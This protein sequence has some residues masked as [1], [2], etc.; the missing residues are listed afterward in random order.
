[1]P[2]TLVHVAVAGLVGCALLAEDFSPRAVGVVLAAGAVP[3]LDTFAGLVLPGAH[4]SL[5]HTLLLPLLLGGLL[6]ADTRRGDESVLRRHW[7]PSAPR[8][9]WV[10]LA[11]L[12]VGGIAPDLATNGVNAFYPLYDA[13]YAVNGE[14]LLSNQRGVVQTFVEL[15]PDQPAQTTETLHYSTGVDPTPGRE[16]ADVERVFPL[17]TSGI[18][19]LLVVAGFGTVALR[20]WLDR[21]VRPR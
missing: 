8:V 18:Q 4:R 11:G 13:F 16:S 19:L 5:L 14:L 20:L 21:R 15:R 17:A 9:G 7:G 2:S 1:V 12:L 3:D 10:A 6:Y